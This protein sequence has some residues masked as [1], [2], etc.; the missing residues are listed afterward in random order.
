MF[1]INEEMP[2]TSKTKLDK[3]GWVTCLSCER[4]FSSREQS[5]H[6][7]VCTNEDISTID[8]L[9]HGFIYNC[10]LFGKPVIIKGKHM[11]N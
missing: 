4:M 10:S 6:S 1:G 2:K 11:R 5:D 7:L 9:L 8:K 3:L